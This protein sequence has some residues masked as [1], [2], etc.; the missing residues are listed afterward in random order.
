MEPKTRAEMQKYM[1]LKDK[2]NFIKNYI[3]PMLEKG[4]IRMCN[5]DKPN[6]S[7]QKYIS[8]QLLNN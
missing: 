5:P 8:V 4:L 1:G 3:A 7:N 2:N 6:S